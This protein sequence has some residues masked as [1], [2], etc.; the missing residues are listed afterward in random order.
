MTNLDKLHLDK[1]HLDKTQMINLDKD[2]FKH[3]R[4]LDKSNL[5]NLPYG[6][7]VILIGFPNSGKTRDINEFIR[8]K[9]PAYER[10]IIIAADKES[11]EYDMTNEIYTSVLQMPDLSTIKG[12]TAIILEDL[13]FSDLSKNEKTLISKILRFYCSHMNFDCYIAAQNYYSTSPSC[14]RKCDHFVIHKTSDSVLNRISN[15]LCITKEQ[16][17]HLKDKYLIDKH[18]SFSVCIGSEIPLRHNLSI[19][20]DESII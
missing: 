8:N 14:R 5:V 20:I 4:Q 15:D 12:H 18:D 16:M 1:T 2:Q 6:S 19:P 17:K 11:R 7:R 13:E 3:L 10:V 9:N